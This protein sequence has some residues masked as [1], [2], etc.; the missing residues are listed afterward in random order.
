L[1]AGDSMPDPTTTVEPSSG[2]DHDAIR[3]QLER[4]L[5][6][7]EFHATD[8]MRAF[9]RFVVDEKLA[10]RTHRL[11]G[12]T[13][14][15]EVFGRAKDF[16]ATNDPI[17][18]IQ[19]G[20]LRRALER[21]YL[22]AGDRDPILIDIPKG[23]Y[24]PRFSTRSVPATLPLARSASSAAPD[25]KPT[26]GLS[27][28]VLP[29]ENLTGN[30]EQLVLAVGLTEE[31]VTELTRFQDCVVVACHAAR[32]PLGCPSD[33]IEL[34]RAVGARFLLRGS[35]RRDVE[36][37]KV[38]AQLADAADGRQIW[39]DASSH[40]LEASHLIATQEKIALGVV[41]AIASEYGVMARRLSAESR[42]KPPA[43]LETYEAMLRYYGHQIAPDPESA[44]VCF[45]A[46]QCAADKEPEYGPVWSALATLHCQMYTLDV[47]GFGDAL[48]GAL[49]RAR[50]GVF[51]EPGSQLGRMILAYASYLA[52]DS[53]TFHQESRTALA[54]NAN[55][56]YTAGSIGY[57]HVMRGEFER[58]LPLL[59]R[60]IAANPCHPAW[61]HAGHVIDHV[62]RGD[63]ETALV[64]TG[65][66]L[67]LMS[68]WDDVMLTALLGKLGRTEEARLHV[69]R[70]M[71]QKPDFAGRARELIRRS[72]KIDAVVD[73]LIDGLQAAGLVPGS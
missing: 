9:L 21:Y 14:A 4:I 54:L 71:E 8:K 60:A 37:V 17:V 30:A 49:E 64:E 53:Q 44:R 61:F 7:P 43:E 55:S 2:F 16:D 58:G 13:V 65:T 24:V 45:E 73:D 19:A 52:D 62:S 6:S 46:L 33:P 63:Y 10:G 34:A 11:K 29:F 20:R 50:R 57:F 68:F 35:V 59:D 23:G 12:Y 66:H 27:V 15:V 39:A 51:L 28:A 3:R 67:P 40:P 48:D 32:Q 25:P 41:G 26:E 47:A 31:I 72:L 18:R 69:D 56:P 70:V 5:A 22:V 38:S 1:V 42:K 36:T